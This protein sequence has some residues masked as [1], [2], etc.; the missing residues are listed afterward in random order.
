[1]QPIHW[2][3]STYSGDGSNCVEIAAAPAAIHVRD[4][5]NAE[6]PHLAFPTA[7]WTQFISH[8]ASPTSPTRD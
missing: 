2:Q 6:G 3:K 5:K 8:T 1:M 7:A 4:S